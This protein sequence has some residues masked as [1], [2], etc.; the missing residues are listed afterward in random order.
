MALPG[1]VAKCKLSTSIQASFGAPDDPDYVFDIAANGDNSTMAVSL[2]TNA[3]KL[4]GPATG[5][6][7]GDC[8]GHTNTISD[9][10]F[11]DASSPSV[12][13]SSSADGTVRAWD[14]RLRKE[15]AT[16][17]TENQELWSFDIG[18]AA[19]NL[20]AS[21]GNAA[22]MCWDRRTNRRVATLEECH[23]EAVTQVR[24]HPSKKEKLV[25]AS[26]DGLMCVFDT[27][28]DINDDE[29]MESVMSVGTSIAKIGFYGMNYEHIWC[30]THIETLSSWNFEDALVEADFTEMRNNASCNWSFSPVEYLIRCYYISTFDTLWLIAGTQEGT[31]GYFPLH[32]PT[33]N[34]GTT[35]AGAVGPASAVLEGG[36]TGVVR[37]VWSPYDVST[38]CGTALEGLFCWT[39]GE[40]GRLCSWTE[41]SNAHE[42]STA[43]VSSGLVAKKAAR[44]KQRR[45]PY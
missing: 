7:L 12:L 25:S 40:D 42:R 32:I 38:N 19:Q 18:G 16:L 45:A 14:I 28:G 27:L 43:W 22:V 44:P 20:V 29:G 21:G 41:D 17:R 3:I 39:G 8:L 13:C 24:F 2:S 1:S 33:P 4:Y 5:Q 31:V 34:T 11:P 9:I 6:Y 23:T 15:V 26:V 36:H 35:S 30:Q 10:S 37:S